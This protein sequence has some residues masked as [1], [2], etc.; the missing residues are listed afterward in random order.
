MFGDHR[1]SAKSYLYRSQRSYGKVIFSQVS[2]ILSTGWGR[3][4]QYALGRHPLEDTQSL[5]DTLPWTHTH[6]RAS[7]LPSPGRHPT[8]TPPGRHPQVDTPRADNP[9]LQTPPW[10]D[11]PWTDTPSPWQTPPSWTD[12]PTLGRHP[13]PGQT[14]S[15]DGH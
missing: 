10:A 15:P 11:T 12:I 5:A 13:H 6:P 8:W 3:I 4:S 1:D 9:L 7:A 2:V 14:P